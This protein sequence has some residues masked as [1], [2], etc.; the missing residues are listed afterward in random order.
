MAALA[1]MSVAFGAPYVAVVA[2]K[3]IAADFGGGRS[4]PAM[5]YSLAW[6]GTAFG[7]LA[8]GRIADRIGVRWTAIFGGR[9]DRPGARPASRGGAWTLYLSFGLLVGVF[10]LG[11]INAPLYVYVSRWF[12]R[13]RGTA[14]ALISSGSY[15]AG[16]MWPPLF[17][18]ASSTIGAGARRCWFSPPSRWRWWCRWP[19]CSCAAARRERRE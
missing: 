12:D 11:G 9:D 5:A 8:M 16:A 18:S 15:V 6:L 3:P 4:V 13:R 2:L 17:A 14:L 1:V 19:R 7:G 10:G